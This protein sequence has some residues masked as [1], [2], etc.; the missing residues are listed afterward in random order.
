MCVW[1][2]G[3]ADVGD[4]WHKI[5]LLSRIFVSAATYVEF[6]G[7]SNGT[8]SVVL[9]AQPT[10]VYSC[11]GTKLMHFAFNESGVN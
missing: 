4:V 9:T 11:G 8:S 1:I 2:A 3:D 7:G 10:Y 5:L 6:V